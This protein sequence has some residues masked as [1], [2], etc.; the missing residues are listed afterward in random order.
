MPNGNVTTL[1]RAEVL[2]GVSQELS[3]FAGLI[4]G[5]RDD[6]LD[7]MTRCAG[8][9]IR[10]VAGHVVGT[11]VDITEGRLEGQGQPSVTA[12]QAKERASRTP[13]ELAAELAS[14][15]PRLKVLL[16]SLPIEAWDG[17]A[18]TG[19]PGTLGFAVEAIWY[20]AYVHADDIRA[21]ILLP[22]ERGPGLRCAVHHIAGYLGQRNGV[23]LTLD[24]DGIDTI[25]V[26][27][28][29]QAVR[30]DP[31]LFILAATGRRGAAEI[32]WPTWLNVYAEAPE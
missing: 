32:G 25:E 17:P 22:P 6:D 8:W 14:A 10:D 21:A 23:S 31:L 26:G 3:A 18:G 4:G 19:L 29:G 1:D 28:G 9:T 11:I 7:T 27:G 15:L 13:R 20:N 16:S 30:G 24:L 12:R 2:T 5:L